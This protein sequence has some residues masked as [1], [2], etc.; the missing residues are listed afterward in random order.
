[1]YRNGKFGAHLYDCATEFARVKKKIGSDIYIYFFLQGA[2]GVKRQT[3]FIIIDVTD[4]FGAKK[5]KKNTR[6]KLKELTALG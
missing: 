2:V 5:K 6:T 1:M 4:V 3:N